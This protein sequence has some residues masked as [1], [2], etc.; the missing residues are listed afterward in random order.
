MMFCE[1]EIIDYQ[2]IN[3]SKIFYGKFFCENF[4]KV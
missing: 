2:Q 3:E 1:E 4:E